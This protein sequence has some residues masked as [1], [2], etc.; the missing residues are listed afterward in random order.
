MK[1]LAK[2]TEPV[3]RQSV[4]GTQLNLGHPLP[5]GDG[6]VSGYP[7]G[8]DVFGRGAR[9]DCPRLQRLTGAWHTGGAEK[10]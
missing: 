7:P 9:S 5:L 10:G 1:H 2:V 8:C 6:E 3:S 4:V